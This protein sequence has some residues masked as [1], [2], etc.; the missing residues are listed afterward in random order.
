MTDFYFQRGPVITR[1][2]WVFPTKELVES[3]FEEYIPEFKSIFNG[4]TRYE[5]YFHGSCRDRF[6]NNAQKY[7]PKYSDDVDLLIY[8]TTS[9]PDEYKIYVALCSAVRI[10]FKHRL[11]I[12]IGCEK[13]PY[14]INYEEDD[15]IKHRLLNIVE[16]KYKLL[17]V[18]TD[19]QKSIDKSSTGLFKCGVHEPLSQKV[20]GKISHGWRYYK[21]VKIA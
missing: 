6:Y 2:K 15:F 20:L 12:D 5:L 19:E 21:P 1:E 3:F 4:D 9:E 7:I 14:F 11:L 10:G 8:T 17:P 13:K 16:Y 18:I